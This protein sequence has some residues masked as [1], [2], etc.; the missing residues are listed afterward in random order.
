MTQVNM[1]THSLGML[2]LLIPVLGYSLKKCLREGTVSCFLHVD[3]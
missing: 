3:S 1:E 2:I